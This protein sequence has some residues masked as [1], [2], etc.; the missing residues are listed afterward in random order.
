MVEGESLAPVWAMLGAMAALIAGFTGYMLLLHPTADNLL[1]QVV[2]NWPKLLVLGVFCGSPF[3]AW[4]RLVRVRAK[5]SR[6]L[7]AEWCL[8]PQEQPHCSR[9]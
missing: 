9:R 1:A 4:L 5:R 8:D 3:V 2:I 7:R 6:L